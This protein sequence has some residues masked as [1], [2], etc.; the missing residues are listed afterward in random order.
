VIMVS[1]GGGARDS[2]QRSFMSTWRTLTVGLSTRSRSRS[3][4]HRASGRHAI[5]RPAR[6]GRDRG[7]TWQ[8][9]THSQL[10]RRAS[11]IVPIVGRRR[12]PKVRYPRRAPSGLSTRRGNI[13]PL[14]SSCNPTPPPDGVALH[15]H[16]DEIERRTPFLQHA[17]AFEPIRRYAASRRAG[18]R[19]I[20]DTRRLSR[21]LPR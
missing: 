8:I 6:D 2:C 3:P 15:V 20:A 12:A 17:P 10:G 4:H 16:I 19:R 18:R 13:T 7:Y 14:R 21:S 9:A 1:D 5:R 11:S